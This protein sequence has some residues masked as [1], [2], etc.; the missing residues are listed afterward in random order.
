VFLIILISVASFGFV[1]RS[2][3]YVLI[4]NNIEG[5]AEFYRSIGMLHA[6]AAFGDVST[7]LPILENS[8]HVGLIDVRQSVQGLVWDIYSTG[9]IEQGRVLSDAFFHG[10]LIRR[11]DNP[12]HGVSHLLFRVDLILSGAESHV[13]YNRSI[14]VNFL[15]D[16]ITG[17]A[18]IDEMEVGSRYLLRSLHSLPIWFEGRVNEADLYPL[19]H[20]TND[21]SIYFIP[22]FDGHV[23]FEAHG[24][25]HLP[26]LIAD[27]SR[28]FRQVTFQAAH[29]M[30]IMPILQGG[31][32]LI[33]IIAGR[34][35][36]HE[37]HTDANPVA[38]VNFEFAWANRL[39]I[40]DTINAYI[41]TK[42]HFAEVNQFPLLFDGI[43]MGVFIDLAV[44]GEFNDNPA[45]DIELE[46][47]GTYMFAFQNMRSL[48]S[49]IYIPQS[50]LP[51]NL[52]IQSPE[53]W[54]WHDEHI[55]D[56]WLTFTLNEPKYEQRFFLEYGPIFRQL[57]LDLAMIYAHA[58][59][60]VATS[61]PLLVITAFNIFVFLVILLISAVLFVF[62]YIRSHSR[63]IA[64]LRALGVSKIKVIGQLSL[65]S[66]LMITPAVI[67][68]GRLAWSLAITTVSDTMQPLEELID[69]FYSSIYLD[70]TL[71][72]LI[73]VTIFVIIMFVVII[74][75]IIATSR[76]VL[77]LLQGRT[78][79]IK[80]V[81]VEL[82][83]AD[84]E[85]TIITEYINKDFAIHQTTSSM[86][87]NF[88]LANTIEFIRVHILRSRTKTILG[89][90]M[91]LV[92]V[93]AL[94]WLQESIYRAGNEIDRLYDTTIVVGHVR[95]ALP[96]GS[97]R[98][99]TLTHLTPAFNLNGTIMGRLVSQMRDSEYVTRFYAESGHTRSFIIPVNTYAESPIEGWHDAIG[100]DALR[101][102]WE[103]TDA[104]N[105]IH[106]FNDF[107]I[108]MSEHTRGFDDRFDGDLV[109]EFAY[110][111]GG[112]IF[113]DI[114][115]QLD[116]IPIVL[117]QG[118]MD[119]HA[120][121]LGDY[122]VMG[123]TRG[124]GMFEMNY[125]HVVIAGVHNGNI[126]RQNLNES[127][128]LP[129]EQ[130][131]YLLGDLST[132]IA[133]NFDI[134]TTFNRETTMVREGL[135]ELV[136]RGGLVPLSMQ[137]F[138]EELRNVVLA[139]DLT[140]L[141]FELL[142]PLIVTLSIMIGGSVAILL[143]MQNVYNAAVMRVLGKS[144]TKTRLILCSEQLI[145]FTLG[146]VIGLA[147]LISA[148][149]GFGIIQLLIIAGFYI[150]GT[151]VGSVV[152]AVLIT[153]KAPL[154][155]LQVR[156]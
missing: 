150:I 31:Q 81:K 1:L 63:S 9:P 55:P 80:L 105:F 99:D 148:S 96:H 66:I 52:T 146:A 94:G 70:T 21:E 30:S 46:I 58:G 22:A 61:E 127:I 15:H 53:L 56:R 71:F 17:T 136:A 114:G 85:N 78:H 35:L 155:L 16:P 60:F 118:T 91:A 153:R 69:G 154:D 11:L 65:A 76:P 23:D 6:N 26:D 111:F 27:T 54:G 14:A 109:V 32:P 103:N 5:I 126:R 120:F 125:V 4:R 135:D 19:N 41:P 152:G 88:R 48:A 3:E 123:Y 93:L 90:L 86:Q 39:S 101:P 13:N 132:F 37:D 140:L 122:A 73:C 75:A 25:C 33:E 100:Y 47:V 147:F 149:W 82:E 119:R 50:I 95:P 116:V 102:A 64:I 141:I 36:T 34:S 112:E 134:N 142:Y 40:G 42:Q 144:K 87:R 106:A 110:G 137:L 10:T 124:M 143:M 62:L 8:P 28:R 2:A 97:M 79:K 20:G 98:R 74:G 138:D 108:F 128:L 151:V 43:P 107:E 115:A 117:Y 51:D 44:E 38:V 45:Y 129:L 57:G 12:Q 156:E 133:I 130:T 68:G 84:D 89:I 49:D 83:K 29:D 67:L 92:F 77:A 24:L 7:A 72:A 18:N 113:G 131:G 121:N 139:M 145:T 104:L 59:D